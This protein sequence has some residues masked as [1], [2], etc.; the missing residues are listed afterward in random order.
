MFAALVLERDPLQW[1]DIPAAVEGWVQTIGGFAAVGIVGWL[2]FIWLSGRKVPPMSAARQTL[3]RLTVL[4]MVVGYGLWA[5]L[6]APILLQSL[7]GGGASASSATSTRLQSYA[8]LVGGIS[9]LVTICLPF[10]L[11]FA[12]HWRWRR[13]WALARLSF[14]EA[15][16]NRILWGFSAFFVVLLFAEW[17]VPY[18]SEDQVRNYVTV[19]F[20]TM[21]PLLLIVGG[22]LAALSIP[23]DLRSQ[24]LHTI[25]TKPVERFEIVAGRFLGYTLLISMV[26]LAMTCISELYLTREIHP[27]AQFESMK[28]R[29]PIFGDLKFTQEGANV[30]YEWEY[31]KYIQGGPTSKHRAYW[32]FVDLPRELVD[33]PTGMVPCEITFDIYRTV[34]GE[35]G[36]PVFCS[37][38]FLTPSWD[39]TR[40]NEYEELRRSAKGLQ[41][42]DQKTFVGQVT[43]LILDREPTEA[44]LAIYSKDRSPLAPERL[45]GRA[46]AEKFGYYAIDSKAVVDFHTQALEIPAALLRSSKNADTRK[47]AGRES[48]PALQVY[49]KCENSSQYVGMAKRDFY[50][51]AAERAFAINFFKGALGLWM[52]LCIVIAVA[53][54]LSTYMSGIIAW[55][56]AMFLYGLGTAQDF[57][58]SVADNTLVGGGPMESMLRLFGRESLV[59]QL[60]PTPGYH[61]AMGADNFYRVMLRLVLRVVPDV[62][63]LDWM[64]YVARGFDIS[65]VNMVLLSLVLLLGYLLPCALIGYYLMKSREIA[66]S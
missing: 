14:K 16:R 52:R 1:K 30:G 47:G 63:R 29:V 15:I 43:K 9:A 18:K 51:L 13:I 57:I 46:L 66:S 58:K 6:R 10:I 12:F 8:L 48:G 42:A 38:E 19:V 35:E 62:N 59:S 53:I 23:N 33:R 45:I 64:Q 22:L 31:R 50:I 2:L 61:L 60:D 32:T 17:F 5:V 39:P 3:L 56:C 55:L 40:K 24:A 25:V 28:A 27:D 26:L 54:V 49:V 21:A 11:D 7:T 34:K 37:F 4:C 20:W 36:K 41:G 44:E 65:M